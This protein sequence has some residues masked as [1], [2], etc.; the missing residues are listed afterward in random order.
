M[1]ADRK[2]LQPSVGLPSERMVHGLAVVKRNNKGSIFIPL[3]EFPM[4]IGA[5]S[6]L[7]DL[8]ILNHWSVIFDCLCA[9]I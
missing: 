9:V 7:C 8:V 3:F 4:G 5:A 6:T 2:N 1:S